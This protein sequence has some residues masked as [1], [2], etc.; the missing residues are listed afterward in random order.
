MNFSFITPKQLKALGVVG[1]NQRNADF[2]M[3]YNPRHLYPLVDDKLQTKKLA[4]AN[5]IKVPSLYDVFRSESD[6]K[7]LKQIIKTYP[8][9]VIKPAHG[10]GGNGILVLDGMLSH[11][12]KKS[13]GDIITIEAIKHHI[14]NILSGMYSLGGANDQ[15]ILEYKVQFDPF[16]SNITYK[17]VPDIRLILFRGIPVAAMIR[18]PTRQSDGKA[19]LHQGAVGVGIDLISGITTHGVHKNRTCYAHPDTMESISDI[20][21][22]NWDAIIE[23][24]LKCADTVKLGYLGVDIVMDSQLGPLVLELNARPGLNVQLAIKHGL[25]NRLAIIRDIPSIPRCFDERR[26]IIQKICQEKDW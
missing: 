14:S 4:I 5:G 6:L 7:N 19:N 1:M 23:L 9:S 10:S 13:S 26:K 11:Y 22:P 24:A 20:R 18:L 15:A 3:R 16:F 21:I 12:V 8:H 17:G 2:V 25:L